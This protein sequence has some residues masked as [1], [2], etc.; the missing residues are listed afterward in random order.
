MQIEQTPTPLK[1]LVSAREVLLEG[2]NKNNQGEKWRY[3]GTIPN[4]ATIQIGETRVDAILAETLRL[5]KLKEADILGDF[6]IIP[7]D[8]AN[9]HVICYQNGSRLHELRGEITHYEELVKQE[10]LGFKNS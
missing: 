7:L 8:G 9:I 3:I 4:G 10:I 1:N 5:K 6:Q 2:L